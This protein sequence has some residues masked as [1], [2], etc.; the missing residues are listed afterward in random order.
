MRRRWKT[1]APSVINA[2]TQLTANAVQ[3]FDVS[4]VSLL[5]GTMIAGT[6]SATTRPASHRKMAVRVVPSGRGH[7][8]G[9][10]A[11]CSLPEPVVVG[12]VMCPGCP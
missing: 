3:I 11:R 7:R 9:A 6:M 8:M 4:A 5:G 1:V 12:V 2:P 10:W